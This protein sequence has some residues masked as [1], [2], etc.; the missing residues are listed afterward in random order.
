MVVRRRLDVELVRR[1]LLSSREMAQRAI[2]ERRVLVGGALAERSARQVDAA[3]P[4]ELV[5]PRPRFVGRGGEKLDAALERF[6]IDVSGYTVLDAGAS[7]GGFTDCV[8]QRGASSVVAVDVGHQ[9]LHERL[10]ADCRVEVHERTNV[11]TWSADALGGRRFD[12][13]VADLSFISL[14]AV[15]VPLT[16]RAVGPLVVLIKPQFEAGRAEASRGRGVI[17]SRESWEASLGRVQA[18]FACPG[19]AMIGLMVSPI[20]GAEGNV[21][22]LAHFSMVGEVVLGKLAI[23]ASPADVEMP[24]TERFD[25]MIQFALDEAARVGTGGHG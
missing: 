7:T 14:T 10:R 3:E 22:F 6:A 16:C 13:V 23:L 11:R 5:G 2:D 15:A 1:G 25:A 12:L 24:R 21:E 19:A 18:A 17:R 8:L 9:Q 20:T 4:I